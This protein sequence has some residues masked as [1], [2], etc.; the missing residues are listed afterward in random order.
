MIEYTIDPEVY[1]EMRY[2][3]KNVEIRLWNEKSQ[4]IQI[5]DK[6]K[7]RVENTEK[8][9]IVEV[10]NQSIFTTIDELYE[11]EQIVQNCVMHYTKEEC[12]NALF[13]IF[14]KENVPSS[15]LVG[16]EFKIDWK[17]MHSN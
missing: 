15:K 2:G 9:L 1:H 17:E 5:G 12:R 10:T 13:K 6:I 4:K 11:N 3:T 8:Y 14:G 16:I 7:F